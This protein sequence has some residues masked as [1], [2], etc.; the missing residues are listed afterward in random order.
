MEEHKSGLS[1]SFSSKYKCLKLVWFEETNDVYAAIETEKKI[2]AG[3]RQKK[4]DLIN[5][6]NPEWQNLSKEWKIV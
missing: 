6:M 1:K 4:M 5:G 3:F 2:K